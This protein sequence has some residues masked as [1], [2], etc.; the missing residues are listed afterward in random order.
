MIIRYLGKNRNGRRTGQ[1]P[2]AG[3][4]RIVLAHVDARPRERSEATGVS[5]GDLL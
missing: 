3:Q 5:K 2:A 4:R 1:Y